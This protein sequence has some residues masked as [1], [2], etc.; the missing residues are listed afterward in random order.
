MKFTSLK[1]V[2]FSIIFSFVFTF[3]ISSQQKSI[4][5]S[6]LKLSGEGV[7]DSILLKRYNLIGWNLSTIDPDRS[8][9]YA[10]KARALAVDLQ[11]RRVMKTE[12]VMR[13]LGTSF[14]T[15]GS[16]AY[17][18]GDF[19]LA[20]KN[21]LNALKIFEKY[22]DDYKTA[23]EYNNLGGMY[24]SLNNYA[25]GLK[26]LNKSVELHEKLCASEP[27]N[28]EYRRSLART[29][30]NLG[31]MYGNQ[32]KLTDAL[33]YFDKSLR[34]RESIGDI[35][36]TAHTECNIGDVYMHKGNF[37][38][39]DAYFARAL[40]IFR[41]TDDIVGVVTCLNNIGL[42][43]GYE[44]KF[45]KGLQSL[46]EAEGLA[47]KA[48]FTDD[49]KASY[50]GFATLYKE[51]GDFK[52][53]NDYLYKFMAIKD[54]LVTDKISKQAGELQEK[55]QS[56]KK[57]AQIDL[58]EQRQRNEELASSRQKLLIYSIVFVLVMVL[59]LALVLWNRNVIKQ[60]ANTELGKQNTLIEL[61]KNEV[62]HQKMVIEEKQKEMLDSILYARRIQS[63]VITS[64]E[65]L[66]QYLSDYFTLYKPKDIV[67]GD[68][69]WALNQ[70]N[71]FYLLTGDCTGHGVPGA[72]M[73]L[74]MIS[75]L[76]EIVIERGVAAPDQILNETR[77]AII[78]ALNPGGY[79][80]AKDGMDCTL[81]VFDRE[82]G[83]LQYASANSSFY[84]IR[85]KELILC[86]GDK[87]PIGKSPK[88]HVPFTLRSQTLE[89][90]DSVYTL[91]DGLADQ[92]GGPK[93]KKF[94]YKQFQELI[95][96]N[97]HLPMK[98]QG[99]VLEETIEIWRGPLE[100][101][102]DILVIGIK[103]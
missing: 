11:Q 20:T 37:P 8:K 30:N 50:E 23:S 22:H 38:E 26:Y 64:N 94:K 61:Q 49:L 68:F 84:L 2:F 93:G 7:E 18:N 41:K 103:I 96:A 80:E 59:S 101:V 90:G 72:F 65:Y 44:K 91:S 27:A 9:L 21:F 82:K 47:L 43:S 74:L 66:D 55:Y 77:N 5:D 57:Q 28:R 71:R 39:A 92:F 29:Y 36:G 100:Q 97:A 79:E 51:K 95:S 60:R 32:D 46:R 15:L 34:L 89:K 4:A 33:F 16:I 54:T 52:K 48:H 14:N 19:G 6:V 62:E 35:R 83:M 99:R 24:V 73:S 78:R 45:D 13:E 85:N 58:L 17:R 3:S 76:N 31:S 42:A 81:C 102:D 88:D 75:I 1:V 12:Q 40:D 87:M 25:E 10:E 98:E 70:N 69:Y 53:A 56:S 86:P 67:S 63:A